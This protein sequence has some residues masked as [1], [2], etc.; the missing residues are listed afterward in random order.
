VFPA[1]IASV[2]AT[3]AGL[4][5]LEARRSWRNER[6]L[7]ARGAVEPPGDVHAIMAVAYPAAFVAIVVEGLWRGPSRVPP[8]LGWTLFVA[9]KSLK[10]WAIAALGDRWS[11]RVLAVPGAPLVTSGPYR[12]LRHPNYLAVGG[13][14]VSVALIAGAPVAGSIAAV[15]FGALLRRRI[16]VEE[17]L[18]YSRRP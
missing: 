11:F 9:A 6:N 5:L 15:V 10:Y 17:A 3:V 8:A 14:I 16:R 13:E 12:Y 7:R 18:L 2:F 4:M 1:S